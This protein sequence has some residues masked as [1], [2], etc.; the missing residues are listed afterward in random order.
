MRRFI[1]FVLLFSITA[2]QSKQVIVPAVVHNVNT[3]T[4]QEI[5][6]QQ[7]AHLPII[8]EVE[9]FYIL[10]MKSPFYA[11]IDTGAAISSLDCQDVEIFERDGERWISF[12]VVNRKS[13][14]EHVF[15]KKINTAYRIRRS[16]KDEHRKAVRMDIKMGGET[17]SAV[18][19]LADR[20]SFDYQGLIGRNVLTGRYIVDT[21][22]SYILN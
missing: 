2:C 3:P 5:V 10:P 6:V 4:H 9:P 11:R 21:S 7:K 20:S 1:L 17:F 13:G 8:G 14:E 15:E 12:K 16:G 19:T 22:T 18:F